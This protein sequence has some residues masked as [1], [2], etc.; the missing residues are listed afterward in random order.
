[1]HQILIQHTCGTRKTWLEESTKWVKLA[2]DFNCFWNTVP[3]LKLEFVIIEI[4]SN[5]YVES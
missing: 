5:G 4:K 3:I 2:P 1:M